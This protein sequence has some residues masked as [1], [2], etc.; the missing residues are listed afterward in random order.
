MLGCVSPAADRAPHG[1]H[2][3]HGSGSEHCDRIKEIVPKRP[4]STE[5]ARHPG[6][7]VL[8]KRVSDSVSNVSF[9]SRPGWATL[10]LTGIQA[11]SVSTSP[12][13]FKTDPI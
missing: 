3:L 8:W 5:P 2:V 9:F 13:F 6:G 7:L 12:T 4:V 1:H 10:A 11:S